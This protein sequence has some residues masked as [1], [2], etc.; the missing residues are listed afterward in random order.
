MFLPASKQFD[1]SEE[2]FK[3]LRGTSLKDF[4]AEHASKSSSGKHLKPEAVFEHARECRRQ[5]QK[6]WESFQPSP[7]QLCTKRYYDV[8]EDKWVEERIM[9]EIDQKPFGKGAIRECFRMKE[10]NLEQRLAGESTPHERAPETPQGSTH[11]GSS[12]AGPTFA[13]IANG[14][15]E[16]R[17]SER[18]RMW[19]AKRSMKGYA[20]LEEHRH[21]CCVDVMHQAMAK[22]SAEQ[23]NAALRQAVRQANDGHYAHQIDFLLTHM[24]QFEDG[25]TYGSEAFL[26]GDYKKHNNNSGGTMG[27]KKT[28]Q[29]FSYFTFINS[30]RRRMIV[31]IQG[32]DDL[33]TDPVVHF[34]PSHAYGSFKEA[35]SSVNLGIRGFALFLWSHRYNDVDRVLDLPIFPL[36]RSELETPE[37]DRRTSIQDLNKGHGLVTLTT[38]AAFQGGK[39]S[40]KQGHVALDAVRDIDVRAESWSL[41]S[42]GPV[43]QK[44]T[45]STAPVLPLELIEASCHMEIAAMYDEGRL[46]AADSTTRTQAELEAAV[47]HLVEAARQGLPEALMAFARLASDMDHQD[48]LPQVVSSAKEKA[49]CL[50]LLE[51]AAAL[52]VLAAR[53]ALAR[54][55]LDGDY[56]SKGV[57]EMK[58]AAKHL[59]LFAEESAAQD[60]EGAD[61]SEEPLRHEVC[62]KHGCMFGWEEHGWAPHAA[63][64]R[65]AELY[66]TELR[67]QEGSW[68]KAQ[69][70]WSLAAECALEDPLL[71]KQAMRYSERAERDEPPLVET[72]EPSDCAP[73]EPTSVRDTKTKT[74]NDEA[75]L[76]LCLKGPLATRFKEFAAGFGSSDD[77]LEE[78]LRAYDSQKSAQKVNSDSERKAVRIRETDKVDADIWSMLGDGCA[79]EAPTVTDPADSPTR[80]SP[81]SAQ[82]A[83]DEDIWS[84]I[85]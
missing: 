79:T 84:M 38:K 18:R 61:T 21:E 64:A 28:P 83:C 3:L 75:D 67:R 16:M 66:E 5:T 13:S 41:E 1:L 68:K 49:L 14:L 82:D 20:D 56:C 30:G 76:F 35:D 60:A 26:F 8:A 12:P 58:R 27:C 29:T 54:L 22:Y 31:D 10:V 36:A 39:N 40:L 44:S 70:L 45:D 71:A 32:I 6:K 63:Y 34:L 23:Y 2:T 4:I 9:V 15:V 17:H 72:C 53:G 52:G 80:A 69:E 78:L 62:C 74:A 77:A 25:R 51:R 57:A 81:S 19:V 65:A 59:E 24:I 50:A 46:S 47:F 48:F 73:T 33:Y 7:P 42:M 85:G 11:G 55:M 43:P 37:P